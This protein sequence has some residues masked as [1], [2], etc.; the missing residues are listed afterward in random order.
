MRSTKL[1]W[2]E[3]GSGLGD[4]GQMIKTQRL[5]QQNLVSVSKIVQAE[6]WLCLMSLLYEYEYVRDTIFTIWVVGK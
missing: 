2:E 6:V 5:H 3:E 4:K 1:N